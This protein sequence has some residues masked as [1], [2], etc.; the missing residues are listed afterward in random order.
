MS[1]FSQIHNDYLD[2][3]RYN[4]G[5]D[6][7]GKSAEIDV[8]LKW[9]LW[10][11]DVEYWRER[12]PE[13]IKMM[14]TMLNNTL[15]IH[16]APRKEIR[17]GTVTITGTSEC[18]DAKGDLKAVGRFE[19]HWDDADSLMDTLGVLEDDSTDTP[20]QA[21]VDSLPFANSDGDVGVYREFT[22]QAD[23]VAKLLELI[24]KEED[25]LIADSSKQWA[26]LE[27]LYKK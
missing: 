7:E 11:Q 24:D 10:S 12:A 15:I 21:F 13:V 25:A 18:S 22:V 17:F 16:T 1:R 26:E 23:T 3:D 9:S 20:V 14:E 5:Q 6:T 27:S 4:A 8:D 19:E 2:P